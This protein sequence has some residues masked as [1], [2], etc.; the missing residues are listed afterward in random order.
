[1]THLFIN[2]IDIHKEYNHHEN[3]GEKIHNVILDDTN[4][5]EL[6][7]GLCA[8]EKVANETGI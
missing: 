6:E 3:D 7:Q 1:M 5:V 4:A 2:L 8:D